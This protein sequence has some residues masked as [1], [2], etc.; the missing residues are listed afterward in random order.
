M[1]VSRVMSELVM[2]RIV[3][4]LTSVRKMLIRAIINQNAKI[5]KVHTNAIV[6][7]DIKLLKQLLRPTEINVSI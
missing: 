5:P 6:K 2:I 1:V 7:L 4:M 3:S